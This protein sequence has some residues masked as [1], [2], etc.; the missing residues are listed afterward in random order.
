MKAGFL[1]SIRH[2]LSLVKQKQK[3]IMKDFFKFLTQLVYVAFA[4][5][6]SVIAAL[7]IIQVLLLRDRGY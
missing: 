2:G 5:I 4:L 7:T 6:F 3:G 1:V